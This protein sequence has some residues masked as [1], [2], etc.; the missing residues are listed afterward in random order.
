MKERKAEQNYIIV[1]N[2]YQTK[3]V[4]KHKYWEHLSVKVPTFWN[5]KKQ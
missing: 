4:I 5:F 3:S 2:T 1:Q